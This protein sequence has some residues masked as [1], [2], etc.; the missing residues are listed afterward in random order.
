MTKDEVMKEL[1]KMRAAGLHPQLCDT[2]VPFVDVPVLAGHPAEA[3]DASSNKYILLP[4]ELV[5]C[6]PVF[7]IEVYGLSMKDADI[8]PGNRLEVQM[9]CTASDGDIVVAEVDG[10]YTVKAFFTDDRGH[11][12]LVPRNKDFAPIPL[13]NRPWRIIGKVVDIRKGEPRASYMECAQAVMNF[14][15]QAITN[16]ARPLPPE[17]PQI[18]VF[19]QFHQR[20]AIDY[21]A[22]RRQVE[23]VIVMQMR[24]AYEWYAAY[25]VLMD[26]GLIDDPM[27]THF[28]QQMN[29]WFPDAPIRCNADRMG[30]Y[31][32]GYTTKSSTLWNAEQFRRDM[33]QGQSMGAFNTLHHRCEELRAALFPIPVLEPSLPF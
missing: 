5:G 26:V 21:N 9:D 11:H 7:L 2:A 29:A 8:L 10:E 27:L 33:R 15:P 30:D 16:M 25:R 23:R 3:G 18:L 4:R 22:V 19:R 12:W 32:V 20:R 1:E 31:A 17:Q 6:H 13:N 28:A 24:H 14:D